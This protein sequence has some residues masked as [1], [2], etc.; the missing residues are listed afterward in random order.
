MS[1]FNDKVVRRVIEFAE[2][3]S[4]RAPVSYAWLGLGSEGRKEQTLFTDQDNALI[5]YDGGK[6]AEQY[7][8]AFSSA[9]VEGLNGCGIPLCKG[10]VMATN[11]KF[12]GSLGTWKARVAEWI[13]SP[14]LTGDEIVDTYVFLDFRSLH[15]DTALE[16]ELKAH[17][18]SLVRE[19]PLFLQ[20]L[21]RSIVSIPIPVGFFK[22]FIVEKS[23]EHK[24]RLNLKLHGI[25]PLVTCV[26][27]LALH[28]GITEN[29]T[30]ER[31]RSMA[32][33]KALSADQKENLE[34]AF[35]TFLTLKI[36]SNLARVG[37]VQALGNYI[38][39]AELSTKEKQLLKEAFWAVSE[40]QKHTQN[41]LKVTGSGLGLFG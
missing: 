17:L 12:S 3:A 26:K 19:N 4:G 20:G 34:Q 1:E 40:L 18:V 39:P 37:D 22:N 14:D 41:V 13:R 30:L 23:G 35:E 16:K 29:N 9:V 36:R 25:V 33:A 15:G 32:E 27:I 38:D 21:A 31:I 2:E 8:T 28:Q 11:P 10:N 7:F 24:N 6:E 5:F